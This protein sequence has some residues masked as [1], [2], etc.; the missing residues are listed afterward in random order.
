MD[1]WEQRA[2]R[3][4]LIAGVVRLWL[5]QSFDPEGCWWMGHDHQG[6]P[7][8]PAALEHGDVPESADERL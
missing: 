8:G 6:L 2:E 1:L 5:L 7:S 4:F 3:S